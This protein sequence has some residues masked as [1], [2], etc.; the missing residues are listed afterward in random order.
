MRAFLAI[1]I[2]DS[3]KNT[4]S[5]LVDRLSS[6]EDGVSWVRKEAMHLTLWF[7]EDLK[8]EELE[9]LIKILENISNQT[10]PF[11]IEI[12]GTG[13]FGKRDFPKVFYLSIEGE[14]RSL[15]ELYDKIENGF[16][17]IG[18]MPDKPFNPHLTLGRNKSGGSKRKI[19]SFLSDLNDYSVGK[20]QVKHIT[21]FKSELQRSGAVHTPLRSFSFG[22]KG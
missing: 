11:E 14:K 16:K 20:E 2:D 15:R 6:I 22:G 5:K 19:A 18:F 1:E 7:F 12:K 13:F 3:I 4:I 21:L 10:N 9:N 17:E 8:E